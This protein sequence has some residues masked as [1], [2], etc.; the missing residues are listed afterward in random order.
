[1]A[2]LIPG[3]R[4]MQLRGI[5]INPTAQQ[6][7]QVVIWIGFLQWMK[8]NG[9]VQARDPVLDPMETIEHRDAILDLSD[10]GN[11]KEPDWPDAEFVVGNPPFL[12]DKKMRT[13]LGDGYVD[14]VR[15]LYNGR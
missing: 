1:M 4:P 3:V 13:E 7:A 15:K 2:V 12:G 11:P 6:L 8:F 9:F 5:E 10:P 14:A